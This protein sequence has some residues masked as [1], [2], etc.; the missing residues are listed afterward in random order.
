[1]SESGGNGQANSNS[2]NRS[3][4]NGNSSKPAWTGSGVRKGAPTADT[5]RGGGTAK[6]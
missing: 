3:G 4:D 2:G 5:T 1:M 6:Q